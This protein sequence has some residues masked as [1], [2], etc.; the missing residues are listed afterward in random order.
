MAKF[1]ASVV[2]SAVLFSGCIT[3]NQRDEQTIT[4]L[5]K[6]IENRKNDYGYWKKAIDSS[7]TGKITPEDLNTITNTI[8]W[9]NKSE[10]DRL[11]SELLREEAKRNNE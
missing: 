9:Q 3:V 8:E 5:K 1:S 2:I 4:S 7:T 6:T 11:E 10:L